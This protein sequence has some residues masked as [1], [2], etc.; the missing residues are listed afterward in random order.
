MARRGTLTVPVIG[1]AKAGWTLDQLR[2]RAQESVEK[3]GGLD[4]AAFAKLC[5][6][7]QY[8]DGDYKDPA[9]FHT[10]RRELGRAEHLT[11][12]WRF[13]PAFGP[14]W[15]N[16]ATGCA[17][18][19]PRGRR[20]ASGR[21]HLGARSDRILLPRSWRPSLRMTITSEAAVHNCFLSFTKRF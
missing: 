15:S 20:A 5:G 11:H 1:V 18:K 4:R 17:K 16:G 8:V 2:A 21:I 6:L 14:P 12:S 19:R 3:Y 10:L 13:R 9:T 7:L